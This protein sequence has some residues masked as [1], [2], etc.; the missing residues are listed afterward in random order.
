MHNTA[1]IIIHCH[2]QQGIVA[3]VAAFIYR[4]N[5][6][7]LYLDRHTD[8]G[9]NCFFMRI[10]WGLDGFRL[11]QEK[12][13]VPFDAVIAVPMQMGWTL[14]FSAQK[15]RMAVFILCASHC[16]YNLL[17]RYSTGERNIDVCLIIS[18][19]NDIE[20]V[21]KQFQ[22]LYSHLPVKKENKEETEAEQFCLCR[23]HKMNFIILA[24]YMQVLSKAFIK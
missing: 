21:T 23:E 24:R 3:N 13:R 2:D 4:H 17:S 18:N 14:N 10:E 5:G 7:I 1:I 8:W 9:E 19:H 15:P 16:L 22:L 6:N 20:I 12:I 11:P